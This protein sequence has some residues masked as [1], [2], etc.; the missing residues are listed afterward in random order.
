[1]TCR[2]CAL[3]REHHIHQLGSLF[4]YQVESLPYHNH[5]HVDVSPSCR[6]DS[7]HHQSVPSFSLVCSL[8]SGTLFQFV[9]LFHLGILHSFLPLELNPASQNYNRV[10]ADK[11]QHVQC[12]AA[13]AQVR[14]HHLYQSSVVLFQSGHVLLPWHPIVSKFRSSSFRI[15]TRLTIACR[16]SYVNSDMSYNSKYS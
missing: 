14:Y 11:Q 8:S 4:Y 15:Y 16:T 6:K 7:E 12:F 13:M 9:S 5:I 1:M 3:S 2:T 10:H